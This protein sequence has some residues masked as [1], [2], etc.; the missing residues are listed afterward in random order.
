MLLPFIAAVCFVANQLLASEYTNCEQ[1]IILDSTQ[2]LELSW[3]RI[4]QQPGYFYL[5]KKN[6]HSSDTVDNGE[7]LCVFGP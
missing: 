6:E 3:G 4:F 7:Y 1:L 5:I 2:L